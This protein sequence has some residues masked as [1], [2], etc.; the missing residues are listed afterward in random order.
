MDSTL[1]TAA[2]AAAAAAAEN[3]PIRVELRS[4]VRLRCPSGV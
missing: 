3:R 2:A 1:S 4:A